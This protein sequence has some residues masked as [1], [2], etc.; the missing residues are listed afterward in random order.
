MNIQL[1]DA[2]AAM[3][4]AIDKA[5]ALDIEICVAVMDGGGRLVTFARMDQSNW[6]SIFGSQGKAATSAATRCKS[7]VIPPESVVMSRIREMEGNNL[8]Y[9]KGAVPLFRD[10]MLIGAI[11]VGGASADLDEACAEAGATAIGCTTSG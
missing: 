7:G 3:K 4:A 11:G 9:A 6:A 5:R 10:G 2:Q 8:I 1:Q